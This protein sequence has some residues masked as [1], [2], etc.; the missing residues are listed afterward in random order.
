MGRG[1]WVADRPS[2]R[3]FAVESPRA[4]NN[5]EGEAQ[6]AHSEYP[7]EGVR[8]RGFVTPARRRMELLCVNGKGVGFRWLDPLFSDV[9]DTCVRIS[10]VSLLQ[11]LQKEAHSL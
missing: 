7:H 1:P 3:V 4:R 6:R 9:A 10:W 11:K 5:G 8:F 2:R